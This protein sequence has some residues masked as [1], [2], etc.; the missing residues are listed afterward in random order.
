MQ[1]LRGA[2]SL[3][4]DMTSPIPSAG[5]ALGANII[6]QRPEESGFAGGKLGP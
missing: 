5:T 4:S 2:G 6:L 3:I 1:V